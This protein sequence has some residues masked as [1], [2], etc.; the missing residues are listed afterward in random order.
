MPRND[1][2]RR[3]GA[4]LTASALNALAVPASVSDRNDILLEGKKISGSAYKIAKDRAYHHGT[5]LLN[6]N[7]AH[8]RAALKTNKV[9]RSR[10][11]SENADD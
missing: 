1:F 2:D 3:K 5:M 9:H 6:A 10:I 8:L 7:L 11:L 4:E